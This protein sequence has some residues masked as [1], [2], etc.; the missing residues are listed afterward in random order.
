MFEHMSEKV[1]ISLT[2]YLSIEDV[3][4]M[5]SISKASVRNWMKN[6]TIPYEKSGRF[7]RFDQR[8]IT[9][10][11]KALHSGNVPRLQSRRNKTTVNKHV[12]PNE[13]VT[14]ASYSSLAVQITAIAGERL[15]IHLVLLEVALQLLQLRG[16][17]TGTNASSTSSNSLV[18][19]YV[20]GNLCTD[21]VES[22]IHPF[23]E[24]CGSKLDQ[25][26][27]VLLRDIARLPFEY[28]EGDDLL[29]L[30]Y[31]SLTN[32]RQRK[33]TG[34]YYTPSRIVRKLV[35]QCF[36]HTY[37]VSATSLPVVV[38][39]CCGSGNFL[40][41][42]YLLMKK[43]L[44]SEGVTPE[45]ADVLL[46][47]YSIH[48]YDIDRTAVLLAQ[49]NIALLSEPC[50]HTQSLQSHTIRHGDTLSLALVPKADLVIGNPPWGYQFTDEEVERLQQ[51][52][53]TAQRAPESFCLFIE[54]GI[55]LLQEQGILAFVL[56]E[57]LLNVHMHA[58][59]RRY[60]L[61]HT[62][63]LHIS[64]LGQ[65]FSHVNSPVVS[66][67][68][69]KKHPNPRHQIQVDS[70]NQSA[71]MMIPQQQFLTNEDFIFNVHASASE[72]TILETMAGTPGAWQLKGQ[73]DF[74]LGIVTGNN[75]RFVRNNYVSGTEPV[76]KGADVF[77]YNV[78]LG[79]QYIEFRP[80]QFQQV[81]PESKYR[82]PEKLIYR[83]INR[84]LV[85]AYD[86]AQTLSLNSANLI[87]P[88][89]P[90]YGIKYTLAILNSRAAQ[91]YFTYTF[92]SV[93]VLRQHIESLP[94][95]PCEA[96]VQKEIIQLV[97]KL[98]ATKQSKQRLILYE[99]IDAIVMNLYGFTQEQQALIRERL[100]D[101]RFLFI[102]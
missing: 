96:Q 84:H 79:H 7:V 76:L 10:L 59:T 74:A 46:R 24:A 75:K 33:P 44:L 97:D 22:L 95:P 82:A 36:E 69:R 49:I 51:I 86:A 9:A 52:F 29:G 17:I 78:S 16:H 85:F 30:V 87:I 38:D 56:P 4:Q 19:Q 94:L 66:A 53:L 23:M 93:K 37:P 81:A 32:L 25:E 62:D 80:E 61:E 6:G 35:S 45:K 5:L 39:P 47:S 43:Q 60:I 42:A 40:I 27:L 8:K 20:G 64:K 68:M 15:H 1:M 13:Y 18:E 88:R 100:G 21:A 73:C 58:V 3:A 28:C 77:K 99:Q 31:M 72:H 92:A 70:P 26:S 89:V 50:D 102:P 91:F 65:P 54:A 55:R 98:I 14:N 2:S 90:D 63:V 71:T 12:F 101:P 83:F 67:I 41:Q 57:S 34:S 11:Q 48:G